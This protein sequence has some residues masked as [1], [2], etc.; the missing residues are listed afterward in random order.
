MK[1]C[2]IRCLVVMVGKGPVHRHPDKEGAKRCPLRGGVDLQGLGV[3]GG[4]S[5]GEV[6]SGRDSEF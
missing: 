6:T 4:A 5:L 1:P 2:D 3:P